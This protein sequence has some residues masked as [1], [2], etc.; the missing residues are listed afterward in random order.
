[1]TTSTLPPAH[2]LGFDS[3]AVHVGRADLDV[4]DLGGL[5]QEPATLL[6]GQRQDARVLGER[7]GD[8]LLHALYVEG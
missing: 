5:H 7:V 1:M 6:V 8:Q 3:R 2:A 4:G